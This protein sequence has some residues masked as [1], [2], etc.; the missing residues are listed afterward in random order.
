MRR[1]FRPDPT[2]IDTRRCGDITHI[3][4]GEGRLYL[5]TVID[6][7]SRRVVGRSTSNHL[8]TQPAANALKAARHQRQPQGPVVFHPDRSSQ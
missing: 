6:I 1:D 4:T 5:A 2:A 7:A 3:P 8:G